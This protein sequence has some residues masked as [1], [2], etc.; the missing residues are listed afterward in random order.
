M[1]SV[2]IVSATAGRFVAYVVVEGDAEQCRV[3][4]SES[5]AVGEYVDDEHEVIR[6]DSAGRVSQRRELPQRFILDESSVNAV[7]AKIRTYRPDKV[8]IAETANRTTELLRD[9]FEGAAIGAPVNLRASDRTFPGW[10]PPERGRKAL[11]HAA[12]LVMDPIAPPSPVNDTLE[13]ALKASIVDDELRAQIELADREET[14]AIEAGRSAQ[15]SE[16][17]AGLLAPE[18]VSGPAKPAKLAKEGQAEPA[19]GRIA[20]VDPGSAHIAL[21]IAE[22][23]QLPLRVHHVETFELRERVKLPKPKKRKGKLV[24][25]EHRFDE[26]RVDDIVDK[27]VSRLV[28]EGVRSLVLERMLFGYPSENKSRAA[29][30]GT[31]LI[32]TMYVATIIRERA[33]AAGIDVVML[34]ARTWRA[35]LKTKE[36]G[37]KD[38]TEQA[39]F[40]RSQ[41][42]KVEIGKII[43][44]QFENW[45]AQSNDHERDAGG[46]CIALRS[47]QAK[48]ATRL[49]EARQLEQKKSEKQIAKGTALKARKQSSGPKRPTPKEAIEA[50]KAAG[51][52]C[53]GK[54]HVGKCPLAKK[55]KWFIELEARNAETTN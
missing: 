10:S 51:C 20:G 17:P 7:I 26:S 27:L 5:V 9:A 54:K 41:K 23:S 18:K 2:G 15:A 37:P 46:L 48:E 29:L 6:H 36:R 24:E 8:V 31:E 21:C 34:D 35:V 3:V 22:G 44:S 49:E 38:E 11:E 16:P 1:T 4:A 42:Y 13:T 19:T 12:S 39:R 50:R 45:P 40:E 52:Q 14:A 30:Q 28:A 47:Q 33:K 55:P 25:Y 43:R 53:H 32:R